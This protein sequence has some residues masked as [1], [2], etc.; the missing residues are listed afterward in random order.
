MAR[1]AGS[2]RKGEAVA[3]LRH[4]LPLGYV[5]ETRRDRTLF[6]PD[7]K[8]LAVAQYNGN[9]RVWDTAFTLDGKHLLAGTRA[10]IVRWDVANGREVNRYPLFGSGKD[11]PHHL[12][13]LHPTENGRTLLAVSQNLSRKGAQWALHAWDMESSKR[14]RFAPF[15]RSFDARSQGGVEAAVQPRLL[16]RAMKARVIFRRANAE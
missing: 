3:R 6:S 1:R 4:K 16:P 7:G 11:D 9:L 5:G 8:T 12:M 2:I 10:A 15:D 14:L 13:V